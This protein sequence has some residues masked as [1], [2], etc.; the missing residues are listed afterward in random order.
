MDGERTTPARRALCGHDDLF[1]LIHAFYL[2]GFARFAARLLFDFFDADTASRLTGRYTLFHLARSSCRTP[3]YL[4]L[5][6][7]CRSGFSGSALVGTV[8][9]RQL[10]LI[11]FHTVP[12]WTPIASAT[13]P[14]VSSRCSLNSLGT[15]TRGEYG[16]EYVVSRVLAT[17]FFAR[18]VLFFECFALFQPAATTST[19]SG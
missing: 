10:S 18:L 5:I 6:G 16:A 13:S 2:L 1:V 11:H 4:L 14:I 19:S 3:L 12:L 7:I 17:Y 9:L 15:D 8:A